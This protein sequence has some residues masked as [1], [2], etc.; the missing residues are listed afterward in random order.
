[1]P[2]TSV[3]RSPDTAGECTIFAARLPVR[4]YR[5]IPRLLW[6]ALRI[7]RQLAHSP[8]LLGYTFALD[9]RPKTLWTTSAWAHR[10]G[11]AHFDRTA[12]HRTAKK[13]LSPGLL[14]STFVVWTCPID[15]LPV[16]WD[17][18]RAR[19]GAARGRS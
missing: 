18:T 9:M 6:F 1:M 15:Q 7:R 5:Q 17:E 19:L 14:P 4:S 13:S 16:P 8:G 2:W 12:P 11:L 3:G 10:T